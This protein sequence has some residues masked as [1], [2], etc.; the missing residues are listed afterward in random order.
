[1]AALHTDDSTE[2][3]AGG[4]DAEAAFS[5]WPADIRALWTAAQ[6]PH[7]RREIRFLHALG[8]VLCLSCLV[9]DAFADAL[10][11]GAALRIGVV[12]P[13]YLIAIWACKSPNAVVLAWAAIA[14]IALFAGAVSII[15]MTVAPDLRTNYITSAAI[16]I[17]F[18]IVVFPLRLKAAV[19]LA[20]SGFLAIALPFLVMGS[21]DETQWNLLIFAFLCCSLPLAI[22]HRTDRLKDRN[23]LLALESR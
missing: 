6:A 14:P 10:E 18:A 15:A 9:L 11:L 8:L 7:V 17:S 5:R 13:S 3:R 1:M 2:R 20:L 19:G 22:K 21:G 23:F 16:L 12:A 4:L